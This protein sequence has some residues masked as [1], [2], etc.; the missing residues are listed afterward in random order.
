[1]SSRRVGSPPMDRKTG[2][3]P[4]GVISMETREDLVHNLNMAGSKLVVLDFWAPWNVPSKST[5]W[6]FQDLVG[7]FKTKVEFYTLQ[8]DK[9]MKLAKDCGVEALPTFVLFRNYEMIDKVVGMVETEEL[10]K[11]IEKALAEAQE[12]A[13][14]KHQEIKL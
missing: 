6:P 3:A 7:K 2:T 13:Q 12:T 1:M 9:F 14:E 5:M 4:P 10:Q 8:V 11:S